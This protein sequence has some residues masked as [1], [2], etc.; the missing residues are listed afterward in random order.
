MRISTKLLTTQRWCSAC[1]LAKIFSLQASVKFLA[2]YRCYLFFVF[3]KSRTFEVQKIQ[4]MTYNSK[5]ITITPATGDV[6]EVQ[7][8]RPRA[9]GLITMSQPMKLRILLGFR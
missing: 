5:D 4:Y 7:T 6:F 9:H 1:N 2:V 3:I 8:T